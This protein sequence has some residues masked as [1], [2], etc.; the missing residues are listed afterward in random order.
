MNVNEAQ[1]KFNEARAEVFRA[2]SALE[3]AKAQRA[4]AIASHAAGDTGPKLDAADNAIQAAQRKLEI[5]EVAA[6]NAQRELEA[7]RALVLPSFAEGLPVVIMEALALGRPVIATSIAG[8][9][10]LVEPGKNGWLVPAGAVEPLVEA[11]AEALTADP[12]ELDAMGRAGAARASV[13]HDA[14][15]EAAKLAGLLGG[16]D[17]ITA[18]GRTARPGASL[19][20]AAAG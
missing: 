8:V 15:V 19:Q 14:A 6:G 9:P 12:R 11:M 16:P 7:A 5:A 4:K 2:T 18:A 10:E 20:G 1:I 17:A 13:Q 3:G